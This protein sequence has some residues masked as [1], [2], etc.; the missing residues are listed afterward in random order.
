MLLL[1]EGQ[2]GEVW[3]YPNR[4]ILFEGRRKLKYLFSILMIF[5]TVLFYLK[6]PTLRPLVLLIRTAQR[7]R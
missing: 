2:A 6:V 4:G 1:S 7:R 5:G 3:K